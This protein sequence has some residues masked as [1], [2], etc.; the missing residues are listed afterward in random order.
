VTVH[1]S[2]HYEESGFFNSKK[3]MDAAMRRMGRKDGVHYKCQE[4]T[5]G[6]QTAE[7]RRIVDEAV[8]GYHDE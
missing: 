2:G 5:V 6:T 7:H 4:W 3:E 1:P 8:M